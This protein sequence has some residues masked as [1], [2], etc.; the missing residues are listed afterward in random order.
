MRRTTWKK[1]KFLLA[2]FGYRCIY[3]VSFFGWFGE[4]S[5]FMDCTFIY[6]PKRWKKKRWRRRA[7]ETGQQLY[8]LCNFLFNHI[9]LVDAL[10]LWIIIHYSQEVGQFQIVYFYWFCLAVQKLLWACARVRM[11]I[12][13][14][15]SSC[16]VWNDRC[17][18]SRAWAWIER[19]RKKQQPYTVKFVPKH[20]LLRLTMRLRRR[21]FII[22]IT[23]FS[24]FRVEFFF[25][26]N[27]YTPLM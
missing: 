3:F 16:T 22:H 1:R 27:T 20:C 17:W 9:C 12:W 11:A 23:S 2:W 18:K 7:R 19:R 26:K 5:M 25:R 6:W 13:M 14:A 24:T 21:M 8:D 10:W 15:W 4:C